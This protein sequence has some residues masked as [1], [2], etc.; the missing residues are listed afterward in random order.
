[1][2]LYN[3]VVCLPMELH[4][5]CIDFVFQFIVE[6][7]RN[8][9]NQ[10]K[11]NIVFLFVDSVYWFPFLQTT[12]HPRLR[13]HAWFLHQSLPSASDKSKSGK[14]KTK[15]IKDTRDPTYDETWVTLTP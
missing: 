8:K 13:D 15:V 2:I 4:S 1:M 7:Y 5:L 10:I 11:K 6:K 12:D 9:L 14:Q 3:Q